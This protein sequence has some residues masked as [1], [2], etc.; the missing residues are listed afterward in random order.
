[1]QNEIVGWWIWDSDK[2]Q[3]WNAKNKSI[4]KIYRSTCSMTRSL[5]AQHG[6]VRNILLTCV[7]I[8]VS[9]WS[10]IPTTNFWL[11]SFQPQPGFK[12]PVQICR[13]TSF[14]PSLSS[15]HSALSWALSI[16]GSIQ[17]FSAACMVFCIIAAMFHQ[18]TLSW[19][20]SSWLGPSPSDSIS[21]GWDLVAMAL[22]SLQHFI[23]DWFANVYSIINSPS[24]SSLFQ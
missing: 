20:A 17:Y 6:E 16:S 21:L 24:W 5:S 15:L 19:S 11:G 3:L 14:C 1:M 18:T 12:A 22:A 2:I 4:T 10:S 13:W 9:D 23:I 8:W 7:R